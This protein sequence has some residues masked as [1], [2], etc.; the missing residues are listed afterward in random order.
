MAQ[1][2]TEEL[3][4]AAMAKADKRVCVGADR[5]FASLH[6]L[7]DA[8]ESCTPKGRCKVGWVVGAVG[9]ATTSGSRPR[10]GW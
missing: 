4:T 3:I 6:R 7:E 1:E 10:R 8:R 2:L 9:R 5:C